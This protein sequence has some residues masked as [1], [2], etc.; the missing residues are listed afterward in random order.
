MFP[1][2]ISSIGFTQTA[3]VNQSSVIGR[4]RQ[5]EKAIKRIARAEEKGR[6]LL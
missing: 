4:E 5:E 3:L 1:G 6:D 2:S